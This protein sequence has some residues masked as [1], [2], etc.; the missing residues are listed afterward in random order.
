MLATDQHEYGVRL[1]ER[2]SS[3]HFE[4]GQ[5]AVRRCSLHGGPRGTLDARVFEVDA[6]EMER[7]PAF[8]AAAHG[9]VKISQFW[10][11][12]AREDITV[13]Y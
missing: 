12:H 13:Y 2:R 4:H 10:F 7:E 1:P 9:S 5:G 3:R 6:G 11:S 8:F